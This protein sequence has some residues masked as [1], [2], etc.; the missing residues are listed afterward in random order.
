MMNT[1]TPAEMLAELSKR[2]PGRVFRISK[3]GS[4]IG[5]WSAELGRFRTV[6]GLLLTG[7]WAQMPDVIANGKTVP[8]YE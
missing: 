1:K 5:V 6:C 3:S 7:G 2:N 8:E 4:A